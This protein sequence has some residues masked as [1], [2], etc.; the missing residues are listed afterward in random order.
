[1]LINPQYLLFLGGNFASHEVSNGEA[2]KVGRGRPFRVPIQ[3]TFL[4]KL[5]GDSH[6]AMYESIEIG[7]E[8]AVERIEHL[9]GISP[10][11]FL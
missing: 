6:E 10:A 2:K 1:M 3:F 7:N 11:Y 5:F 9:N 8:V 4:V